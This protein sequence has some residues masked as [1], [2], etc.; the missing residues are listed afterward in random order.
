M[1]LGTVATR[2]PLVAPRERVQASLERT[3][4]VGSRLLHMYFLGTRKK[5]LVSAYNMKFDP[6]VTGADRSLH[7]RPTCCRRED[8]L[9][10]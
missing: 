3:G 6:S 2:V 4:L 9:F 1:G 10:Y 8:H 5:K 7:A